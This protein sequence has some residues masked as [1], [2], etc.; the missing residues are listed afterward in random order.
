MVED[1]GFTGVAF[2]ERHLQTEGMEVDS[3]SP[4]ARYVI[5]SPG[6]NAHGPIGY[7]L[8]GWGPLRLAPE[9]AWLDQLTEGCT[10]VGV[11]RGYQSRGLNP[12]A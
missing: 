2:P 11:A 4:P 5:H 12:M 7:V 8:P 3:L 10:H 1:L 6:P 9:I